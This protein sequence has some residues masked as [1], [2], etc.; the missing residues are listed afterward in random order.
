M[1]ANLCSLSDEQL[2]LAYR[3][4]DEKSFE[5]L[6]NRHYNSL[7]HLVTWRT[8]NSYI[9]EESVQNAFERVLNMLKKHKYAEQGK[10]FPWLKNIA[11]NQAIDLVRRQKTRNKHIVFFE[12][13]PNLTEDNSR[14][15]LSDKI[16]FESQI[17]DVLRLVNNLPIKQK[18]AIQMRLEGKS[19][20]DIAVEKGIPL[21]TALARGHNAVNSLKKIYNAQ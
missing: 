8:G 6:V 16:E 3:L 9:A 14:F 5:I 12:A 1:S 15:S 7:R 4:G 2:V 19:Y 11:C 17:E 10:F 13:N 20:Q 21:N 18:E